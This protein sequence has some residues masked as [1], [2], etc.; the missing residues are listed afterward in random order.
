MKVSAFVELLILSRLVKKI[1]Q[2]AFV[3]VEIDS[4]YFKQVKTPKF[5]KNWFFTQ[6]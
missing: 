4:K 6:F 3:L 1:S 5:S 2:K